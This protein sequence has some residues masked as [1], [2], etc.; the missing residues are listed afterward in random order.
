M[1][2]VTGP[3]AALLAANT[4]SAEV[5]TGADTTI[6]VTLTTA[7]NRVLVD[8]TVV[9]IVEGSADTFSRAVITDYAGRAPLGVVPLEAGTYTVKA[10]FNGLIPVPG[11]PF[12]LND[13]H[14][15]PAD[16]STTLTLVDSSSNQTHCS[17][18]T[19]GSYDFNSSLMVKLSFPSAGPLDC[20]TVRRIDTDH[21]NAAAP[22][23]TGHYWTIDGLDSFG[24]PA[25]GFKATMTLPVDQFV[26]NDQSR[27]CR[28][29][30]VGTQ[31]DCDASAFDTQTITRR[32]DHALLRVGDRQE[33]SCQRFGPDAVHGHGGSA[34][35]IARHAGHPRDRGGRG[36]L[37]AR[38]RRR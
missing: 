13:K 23:K 30:G 4:V 33:E 32:G 36:W 1:L 15:R 5:L 37:V 6:E 29:M 18:A 20:V 8:R 10:Y 17:L 35:D 25:T 38:Q 28:Y 14:Y 26:P 11:S 31:W 21:P 24:N 34:S 19:G 3:A 16:T 9:F 12:N 22:L 2:N 7:N 27:V